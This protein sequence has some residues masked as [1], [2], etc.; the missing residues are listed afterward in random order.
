MI[1]N[2]WPRVAIKLGDERYVFDRT[3]LM[4]REVQEI[5][6]ATGLSYAEW[7]QQLSRYSITAIA[8]LLHVLRRR[9]GVPS[10]FK[11]LDFAAADLDVVPLHDDDTEYTPEQAAAELT[12]RLAGAADGNGA[13]PT[14]AADAPAA[15]S[16]ETASTPPRPTSLSSPPVT[17]SNPGTGNGLPGRTGSSSKRTPTR[18]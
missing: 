17:A 18:T 16:G 3:G 12:K 15:P 9:A 10:D 14:R 4:F 2:L 13:D 7:E 11:T 8:A 5:E 6:K 1:F